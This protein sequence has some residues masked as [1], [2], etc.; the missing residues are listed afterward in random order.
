M[1]IS[2]QMIPKS[3]EPNNFS[4]LPEDFLLPDF[5]PDFFPDFLLPEALE[6]DFLLLEPLEPPFPLP[7][8]SGTERNLWSS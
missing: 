8:D 6:P 3:S 4:P 5:F 1:L 2:S 7:D